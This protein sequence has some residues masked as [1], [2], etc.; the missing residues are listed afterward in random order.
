MWKQ[1]ITCA[2]TLSFDFDGEALWLGGFKLD[3]P[4][5]LSRGEFGARV[6]MPRILRL[7]DKY[8]IKATFFVPGYTVESH[9]DLVATAHE[10]GHEI[11]HHGYLHENPQRMELEEEKEVIEKGI[12]AIQ[13]V[14]GEAP[15]GYRVPAGLFSPRTLQLL[16]DYGFLYDSSFMNSDMPYMLKVEG[17]GRELVELPFQW[18]LDDFPHFFFNIR[19]QYVGLSAPSKVYEIWAE[20]FDACYEEGGYFGVVMHPQVIGH[21]HRIRMVEKLINHMLGRP[22]VWFARLGDVASYWQERQD[23]G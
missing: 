20:E 11:A 2:V 21:R 13:R 8:A 10:R 7:L 22:G 6:G 18:E 23:K 5:F 4:L 3:H 12:A 19:P 16:V 9:T 17:K 15:R 1:G 14:T